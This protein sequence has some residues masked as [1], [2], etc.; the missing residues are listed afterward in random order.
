MNNTGSVRVIGSVVGRTVCK[1]DKKI[2]VY[3][4]QSQSTDFKI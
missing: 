3:S 2:F 4:V 1:N